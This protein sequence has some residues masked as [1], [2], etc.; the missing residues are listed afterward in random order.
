MSSWTEDSRRYLIAGV[1]WAVLCPGTTL[2][3]AQGA[4]LWVSE[5]GVK[6]RQLD[7]G[8]EVEG[9]RGWLRLNAVY[10]NFEAAFDV[11]FLDPR[12]TAAVSF[13]AWPGDPFLRGSPYYGYHLVAANDGI[14]R[15]ESAGV[16]APRTDQVALSAPPVAQ[17]GWQ[18]WLVTAQNGVV[19]IRINGSVVRSV[20]HSAVDTR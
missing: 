3:S 2:L 10:A 19:T 14:Q 17:D 6:V 15:I 16:P 8:F 4:P 11:A 12:S 13:Y 18:R 1:L 20:F 7:D 9:N 5:A